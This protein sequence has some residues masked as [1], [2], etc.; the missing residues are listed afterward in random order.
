MKISVVIPTLNEEKYIKQ[1]I[2]SIFDNSIKPF[3]IIICD[4][5]SIDRTKIIAKMYR[6]IVVFDNIDKTAASGRN[7]GIEHAK[8]DIIAFTDGDCFVDKNW[9]KN[10]Q[11][12]FSTRNIDGLRGRI[13]AAEPENIFESFWNNLAWNILMN[14]DDTPRLI[15]NK[16]IREC[17]TTANCAYKKE[18]LLKLNGFDP[19]FGNNAEDADLSWRAL[20]E[21]FILYYDPSVIV[22]AHGVTTLKDIR[23]KSFRNGISS[24]KLQKRHGSFFNFDPLIHKLWWRNLASCLKGVPSASLNLTQVT[25]HLLGKYW[26]SFKAKVINL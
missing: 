9:I 17:L 12:C 25:W 10:I 1:C 24:S 20:D 5:G 18:V 8:G 4:G 22:S 2:N 16:T 14:Y 19:W 21:K 15:F 13:I 3:E 11:H 6:K 23:Q 7:I 26:G